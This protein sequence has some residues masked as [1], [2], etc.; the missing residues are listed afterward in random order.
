[1]RSLHAKR[2]LASVLIPVLGLALPG[3]AS[4]AKSVAQ[5]APAAPAQQSQQFVDG[6]AAVVN[7]TVITLQ[8][9]NAETRFAQDQL[10]RQ[11]IPVPDYSALQK[12][13]LQRMI[14]EELERQ[15]AERLGIKV[16]DAQAEQAVQS[17]AQRNRISVERLRQE[18]EKSGVPWDRYM[19]NLRQEVRMDMLRQR[20]VD[21]T[22]VISDADIDAF[23]KNQANQP[24]AGQQSL[25][26]PRQPQAQAAEPVQQ[27][28][29]QVLGLAQI[30]VA[31][32]EG[33]SSARVQ[34]LR[35]KAESL[36]ARVRGGADFAG[37]AAASS[38]DPK[39]LEGGEMGVR[40]IEGWPDLFLQATKDLKPGDV[41]GIIQS[42]N[43]FHI[44]KVLTRGQ[45]AGGQRPPAQAQ[46]SPSAQGQEPQEQG[47]M[48]V[49]QTQARHILIK[50]TKVMSDDKAQERLNQLRERLVNGTDQFEDMAKR[51]SEDVSAPQGGDLGWLTP[52]ET[53]PAFEKA[54]NELQPGQISF[55]IKSQFGWHLIQV[56]DRRTKNMENEF[57]RM[58][59][60]QIL[61]QRRVEPAFEDWLSQLRGQAYVDNRLDPQSNRN[62]R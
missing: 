18:V 22:I 46:A 12:Q 19:Q 14:A 6:I 27:S 40:P 17:I 5:A 48:M 9:V 32:P 59:A 25:Q 58:Q 52:G 38:D 24:G 33:S 4:A 62:R 42:G 39:A 21:S 3:A 16:T 37:V 44:L 34:E 28:G 13:V 7:Q 49:T 51:Y 8:Q 45:P 2:R 41:S 56:I 23:L 61:F 47:P 43:G 55:P 15:E 11:N 60:R 31:I 1:M 57:R 54:M 26:A 29:P 53:V 50:T 35:K 30:L 36:L 10:K 20:A